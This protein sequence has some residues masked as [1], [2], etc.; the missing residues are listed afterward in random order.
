MGSGRTSERFQCQTC[1]ASHPLLHNTNIPATVGLLK[2]LDAAKRVHH[3]G[4]FIEK[5][6]IFT[7]SYVRDPFCAVARLEA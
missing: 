5:H 3:W 1:I 6:N 2:A 4:T 7:G